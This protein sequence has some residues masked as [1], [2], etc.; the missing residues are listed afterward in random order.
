MHGEL[1]TVGEPHVGQKPFV[2]ADQKC[3][4]ELLV[5]THVGRVYLRSMRDVCSAGV[6]PADRAGMVR[7]VRKV[8]G[9]EGVER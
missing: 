8:W 4:C 1:G 6:T 3:P 7:R 5:E 9:C 2:P